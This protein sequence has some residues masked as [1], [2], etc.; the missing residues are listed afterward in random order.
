MLEEPDFS[1]ELQRRF[2]TYRVGPDHQVVSALHYPIL[3]RLAATLPYAV[4]EKFEFKEPASHRLAGF[5]LGRRKNA[6]VNL[7]NTLR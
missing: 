5:F 1:I 3:V 2:Q 4:L 7:L 6:G